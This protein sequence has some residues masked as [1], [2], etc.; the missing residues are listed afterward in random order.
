MQRGLNLQMDAVIGLR[1]GGA[2]VMWLLNGRPMDVRH[3]DDSGKALEWSNRLR[4]LNWTVGWRLVPDDHVA[5]SS[6]Y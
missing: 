2:W 6:G 4:D 3:F 1:H 5:G